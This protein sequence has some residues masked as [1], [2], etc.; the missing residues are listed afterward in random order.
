MFFFLFIQRP[1]LSTISD[2]FFPYSSLCRYLIFLLMLSANAWMQNRSI[3]RSLRI[4]FE[5]ADLIGIL[6]E[7]KGEAETLN[8]GLKAEIAERRRVEADL[9]RSIALY[10][11]TMAAVEAG[12]LVLDRNQQ[13]LDVKQRFT[14]LWGLEDADIRPEERRVGA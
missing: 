3:D 8:E 6:E 12:I 4:K 10:Q 9:A 13:V 2:T 1:P 7:A 14:V 5:N 11:A